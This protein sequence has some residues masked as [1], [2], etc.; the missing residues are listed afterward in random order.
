MNYQDLNSELE[1][2]LAKLQS[3]D[4]QVDEAVKLYEQGLKLAAELEK[5]LKQAENK[6]EKL[7]I[8]K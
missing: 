6:I 1:E 2:V 4:I 7:K 3:P 8:K 5:Q